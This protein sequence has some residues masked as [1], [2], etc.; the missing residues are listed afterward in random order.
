MAPPRR[1]GVDRRPVHRGRG[2]DGPD[3]R[4]RRLGDPARPAPRRAAGRRRA[5][6]RPLD[7]A[8]QPL[9]LQLAEAGLLRRSTTRARDERR[10]PCPAV[11][12]DHRDGAAARDRAA[13]RQPRPASTTAASASPSTTSARGTPRW[14]TCASTPSTSSRSTAASSATSPPT[15]ST[16][17]GRPAIVALALL[18]RRRHGRLHRGSRPSSTELVRRLGCTGAQ[19]WLYSKAVP[20]DESPRGSHRLAGTGLNAAGAAPASLHIPQGVH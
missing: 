13:Q 19:G 14:P 9:G 1:Q 8:G 15:P 12:R 2:G 16:T 20:A 10:R 7:R 4:H 11:R 17:T 6:A 5:P 3:R 18:D